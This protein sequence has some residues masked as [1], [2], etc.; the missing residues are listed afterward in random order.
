MWRRKKNKVQPPTLIIDEDQTGDIKAEDSIIIVREKTIVN[1]DITG[2]I[3]S[4]EGTVK[5]NIFASTKVELFSLGKV[6][7]RIST[8]RLLKEEGAIH[9]GKIDIL[10]VDVGES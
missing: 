3:V 8:P 9:K 7:G 6:V 2:Q 5:G 4:I 10:G 1:G